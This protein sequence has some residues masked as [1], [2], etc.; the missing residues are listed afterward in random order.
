MMRRFVL[1]MVSACLLWVAGPSQS[2]VVTLSPTADARILS[3]F[4]STNFGVGDSILSVFTSFGND[5]RTL[6]K[7][8]LS[9]IPAG[10]QIDS[11][12]LTLFASTDFGGNLIGLNMDVHAVTTPWIENQATWIS[13][14]TGNP[15]TTAG[16][17]FDPFVYATS[18]ANPANQKPVAWNLN[19]LVQD[20]Y[21]GSI[22]NEG[23]LIR[24]FEGNGLTFYA[25]NLFN[26]DELR[27]FLAIEFSP[28]PEA[29]SLLM[30][31]VGSVMM[32]GAIV[33]RRAIPSR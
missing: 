16:G 23:L 33:A 3:F 31:S 7:F 1:P 19:S 24:S 4:P 20:W 26:P 6:M 21:D 2:A 11:A 30:L 10:Q 12:T 22:D 18:T 5:Q 32:L 29:S 9:G 28:I 8:D 25:N 14:S 15:W 13:A 27:P 17:D